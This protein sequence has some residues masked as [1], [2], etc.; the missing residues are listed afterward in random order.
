ML[1]K[2]ITYTDF[3]DEQVT[4]DHFFH[5]SKA[6]LVEIEMSFDGGLSN[7]LERIIA[8]NDGKTIMREFKNIIL[9]SYGQKSPDGKR[10]IK[11]QK[12]REE[13]ES[14]EA[15]S[16]LFMEL[17][18]DAS[19]ASDF[20]NGVVP[21]DLAAEAAKIVAAKQGESSEKAK[22]DESTGQPK[23]EAVGTPVEGEE[24]RVI[25]PAEM[26]SASQEE[27]EQIRKD[28]VEGRAR[29]TEPEDFKS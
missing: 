5:L 7:A 4:E 21:A 20:I 13:F 3:N 6:E 19:A 14:S 22:T 29:L 1:K 16:T 28:I 2:T 12:L 15:Y 26:V 17:L 10:F 9:T 23:L 24:V 25:Y 27:L 11:N 8:A 18:T